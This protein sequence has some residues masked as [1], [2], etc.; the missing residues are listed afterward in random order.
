MARKKNP[1]ESIVPGAMTIFMPI[2]SRRISMVWHT[3]REIPGHPIAATAT[4]VI[5]FFPWHRRIVGCQI[6]HSQ[7]PVEGVTARKN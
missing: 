1:W 5:I 6:K 3:G 7:I 2:L 4:G